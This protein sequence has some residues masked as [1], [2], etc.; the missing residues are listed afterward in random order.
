VAALD[1]VVLRDRW[2]RL[3]RQALE[4]A[5]HRGAFRLARTILAD[6]SGNPEAFFARRRGAFRAYQELREAL[7]GN[8]PGNLHPFTVLS[9]SL[10]AL[11]EEGQGQEKPR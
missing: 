9:R 6:C 5:F 4:A 7:R 2:D 8:L 11:A 10:E 1:E 3:A